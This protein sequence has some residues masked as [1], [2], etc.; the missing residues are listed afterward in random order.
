MAWQDRSYYRDRP[1][2]GANPLMWL[3]TGSVRLFR[4]FGIEVRAHAS[5][6]LLVGWSYCRTC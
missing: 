5:L 2:T 3:L 1:P 6:L 4:A